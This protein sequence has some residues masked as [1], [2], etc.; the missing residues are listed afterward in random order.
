MDTAELALLVAGALALWTVYRDLFLT[1]KRL[2]VRLYH[3]EWT[4]YQAIMLS[5]VGYR[6]ITIIIIVARYENN[7]TI[8][9]FCRP[10][11]PLPDPDDLLP[12]IINPGDTVCHKLFAD[13]AL[14]IFYRKETVKLRI[15]DGTSKIHRNYKIQVLGDDYPLTKTFTPKQWRKHKRKKQ[16]P[17]PVPPSV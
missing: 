8:K 12:L 10:P 4:G 15:E 14:Q 16:P 1:W 5:N 11:D 13:V 9:N 17:A 7:E 2:R 6:P 3:N